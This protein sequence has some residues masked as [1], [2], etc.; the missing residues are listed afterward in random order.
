[1]KYLAAF[2]ALAAFAACD[3]TPEPHT[4]YGTWTLTEQLTDPGDGS[5]EFQEVESDFTITFRED[6]SFIANGS[7]CT[8]TAG[9][10]AS[11]GIY[12]EGAG[13]LMVNNCNGTW[14]E[15]IT[16]L[17]YQ[18]TSQGMVEISFPCIEPCRGRFSRLE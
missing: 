14:Q 6:G 17:N 9:T 12:N 7:L 8:L 18:F 1:M 11:S 4:I 2:L 15:E 16:R 5:G 13:E 10:I 3:S